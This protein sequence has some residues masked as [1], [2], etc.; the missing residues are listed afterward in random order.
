MYGAQGLEEKRKDISFDTILSTDVPAEW[1]EDFEL[2]M[3]QGSPQMNEV[4][5]FH[6][7]TKTLIVT[8]LIFNIHEVA[9][10]RTKFLFWFVGAWKKP[11]QSKLWRMITKDRKAAGASMKQLLQMDFSR[12]VMAHGKILE[13]NAKEQFAQAVSWMLQGHKAQLAS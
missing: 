10:L 2:T 7:P 13:E 8:D 5:F 1:E 6:K 3:V 11:A 4:V 9:N 12:V